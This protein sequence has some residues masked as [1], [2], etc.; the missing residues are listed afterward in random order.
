MSDN[1]TL[2]EF[3][4]DRRHEIGHKIK[5]AK[6]LYFNKRDAAYKF[7]GL[8]HFKAITALGVKPE[9]MERAVASDDGVV[10]SAF[11]V[12]NVRVEIKHFGDKEWKLGTYFYKLKPYSDE[13]DELAYFLS[14]VKYFD[15]PIKDAVDLMKGNFRII[16]NIPYEQSKAKIY[17]FPKVMN[18]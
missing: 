2:E 14:H 18:A 16:T 8:C 6:A 3:R 12:N 10:N 7:W 5:N 11:T 1:R 9:D 4:K 15:H 17:S 13:I